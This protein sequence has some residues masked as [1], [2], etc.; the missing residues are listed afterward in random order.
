MTKQREPFPQPGPADAARTLT[1]R[2]YA[3]LRRDIVAGVLGPEEKLRT[4]ALKDRYGLGGSTLRE[5]LTRLIGEALVTFEG[6]RGFRVAPVSEADFADLCAVRRLVEMEAMRQSIQAGD[7]AW[8]A[9]VV[10][11]HHRL[12]R[13]EDEM[14]ARLEEVYDEWEDRNREFHKALIGA[15]PSARLHA[16]HDQLMRQAERYRRITF[17]SGRVVRRNVQAEHRAILEATLARDVDAACGLAASHIHRTLTVFGQVAHGTPP[18]TGQH[19]L[20]I[21]VDGRDSSA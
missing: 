17:A 21:H 19:N 16:I 3:L 11:A 1:E 6:Q 5:A 4:E 2:A 12:S 8:E 20:D 13:V 15:C 10:A 14:P 7:G 9:R 18:P